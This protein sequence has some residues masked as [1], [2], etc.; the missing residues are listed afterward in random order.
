VELETQARRVSFGG[1][2]IA[3]P[4]VLEVNLAN[5]G[6]L[7]NVA[8]EARSRRTDQALDLTSVTGRQA[9]RSNE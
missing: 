4:K 2:D 9:H 5:P 7:V 8:G 1:A 3:F 6:G